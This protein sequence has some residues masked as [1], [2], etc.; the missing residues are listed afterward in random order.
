MSKA[1]KQENNVNVFNVINGYRFRTVVEGI[2]C[3]LHLNSKFKAKSIS[4]NWDGQPN[5]SIAVV[6]AVVCERFAQTLS[7]FEEVTQ[8]NILALHKLL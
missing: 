2:S 8:Q 3:T 7:E 6:N 4:F 5:C 1:D